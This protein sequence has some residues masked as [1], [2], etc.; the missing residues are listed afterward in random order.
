MDGYAKVRRRLYRED[1]RVLVSLTVGND[2]GCEDVEFL[3][4]GELFAEVSDELAEGEIGCETVGRI[5]ELADI[6]AAFSSACESLAFAQCSSKALFR[7]LLAK[8]FSRSACESA[9]VLCECRGYIDE[10]A[11][12]RRRAEIMLDK[13]W[14]RMRIISKLREEGYSAEALDSVREY[15]EDV[16][17]GEIC[18]RVIVKKYHGIPEDRIAREKMYAALARLGFSRPD[19]RSALNIIDDL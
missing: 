17:F 13:L 11:V 16:D 4:L 7:K 2:G 3:I 1:G 8:G 18:S 19:I 9:V 5:S 15:L 10:V 6:T 14:G 12:A